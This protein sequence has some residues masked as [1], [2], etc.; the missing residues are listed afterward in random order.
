MRHV[1]ARSPISTIASSFDIAR[2]TGQASRSYVTRR[3]WIVARPQDSRALGRIR[4]MRV[5]SHPRARRFVATG[6]VPFLILSACAPASRPTSTPELGSSA[7][8]TGPTAHVTPSP[9]P[10][11]TQRFEF[12]PDAVVDTKLVGTN[13]KFIN[14]GAVIERDGVLHMFP[15]SFS[16]WPGRMRIPHLTSTDGLS[17]TLDKKAKPLDSNDV[18]LANPGMDVSTGFVTDDGTW[19]LIYETVSTS[20]AWVLARATAPGPEGPWTVES[21]PILEAGPVGAF[22]HGGITWPSVIRLGDRWAMY[23][24]GVDSPGGQGTGSMGVAFSTDGKTWTKN[25]APVMVATEKWEGRSLDRPRVVQTPTGSLMLYTGR[26]LTDR[27]LAT[28]T[29]GLTWTKIPGPNIERSD[30]P[31]EARGS[32]DS[33]LLHRANQLEYF[34][35][36]GWETTKIYRATLAWP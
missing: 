13:D 24:A 30:F 31:V 2:S 6:I 22:D 8:T 23:Y 35:E 36:I 34:L 32:W 27:G 17:W 20:A 26:D 7:P 29:D 18:S 12:G 16:D 14:P 21:E 5:R 19:V 10:A 4:R 33:A 15:N 28:S 9:P 25:D 3:D 11:V 1:P